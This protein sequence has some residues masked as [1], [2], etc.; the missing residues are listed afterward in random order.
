MSEVVVTDCRTSVAE[1][2]TRYRSALAAYESQTL[3][4]NANRPSVD[5]NTYPKKITSAKRSDYVLGGADPVTVAWFTEE[6]P[7][8]SP[9]YTYSTQDCGGLEYDDKSKSWYKMCTASCTPSN[10]SIQSALTAWNNAT[11]RFT[12]PDVKELICQ[13]C[14]QTATNV[15]SLGSGVKSENL[16]QSSL[17]QCVVNLGDTNTQQATTLETTTT[18]GTGQGE[19]RPVRLVTV[20]SELL[21][22]T[23]TQNAPP[24]AFVLGSVGIISCIVCL[25]VAVALLTMI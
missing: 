3:A 15:L 4:H 14:Q 2:M 18:P 21:D 22:D 16:V 6:C 9:G 10:A 19:K 20:P 17:L 1:Y 12:P 11:P 7:R 25:L 24:S 5:L 8:I 23:T 13:N